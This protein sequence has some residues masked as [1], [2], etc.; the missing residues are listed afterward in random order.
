VAKVQR[1]IEPERNRVK[2][3]KSVENNGYQFDAVHSGGGDV[4]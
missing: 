4:Q 1:A 3:K 2:K